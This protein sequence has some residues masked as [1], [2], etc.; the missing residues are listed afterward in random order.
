ME[1]VDKEQNLAKIDKEIRT[2]KTARGRRFLK[3]REPQLEESSKKTIFIKGKKTS[4]DVSKIMKDIYTLKKINSV[5]FSN[6][7]DV[8]PFENV[9]PIENYC[10]K[11][12]CSLFVFG[13][14]NKKRPDNL[15]LGRLF[16]GH[17]LDMVEFGV[18]NMKSQ[19]SFTSIIDIPSQA[20]PVL[21]FQ[22]P[23]FDSEPTFMKIKNLLNDFFVEN[24]NVAEIDIM[25]GMRYSIVFTANEKNILMRT[26]SI[27][28]NKSEVN[29]EDLQSNSNASAIQLTEIGPSADLTV[30]REQWASD[31]TMKVACKQPKVVKKK[32]DKNK[33]TNALGNT[34]AKIYTNHQNFN[35]LAL[36]KRKKLKTNSGEEKTIDVDDL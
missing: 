25:T 30:R 33:F 6:R 11:Q 16:D 8:L 3:K 31:E 22:G 23:L 7:H 14:H 17:L 18:S 10:V 2:A 24:V 27:N 28:I 5:N 35:M 13:S 4:E 15:I 9:Q 34:V 21:V 32:Q 29:K 1:I 20:R 19:S 36:K 12:D 26:Y